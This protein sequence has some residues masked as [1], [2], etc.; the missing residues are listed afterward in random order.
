MLSQDSS[1]T[2]FTSHPETYIRARA[3]ALWD[4]DSTGCEDEIQKLLVGLPEL[5][6]LDIVQQAHYSAVTEEFLE[7]LLSPPWFQTEAVL[8]QA[9]LLFPDFEVSDVSLDDVLPTFPVPK[10]INANS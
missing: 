5:N 8:G 6:G 7:A 10:G 9:K 1:V 3:L 4:A 2:E